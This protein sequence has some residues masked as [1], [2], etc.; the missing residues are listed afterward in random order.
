[1]R[2]CSLAVYPESVVVSNDRFPAENGESGERN[3]GISVTSVVD[4]NIVIRP[5]P[6][7]YVAG[8]APSPNVRLQDFVAA[9]LRVASEGTRAGVKR[10][11]PTHAL[12][13]PSASK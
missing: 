6:R 12:V 1:M 3:A 13:R 10:A 7:H 2:R 11:A 9:L 4:F 8:F 5:S